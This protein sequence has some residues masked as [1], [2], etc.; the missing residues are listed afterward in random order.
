[1]PQC[2]YITGSEAQSGKSV[3]VL[4]LVEWLWN[5]GRTVGFFRPVIGSENQPDRLIH[6]ILARYGSRFPYVAMYGCTH[7]QALDLV[8][9]DS[10]EALFKLILDKYKALEQQCD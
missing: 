4:G 8:G 1:M 9:G 5:Q 7:E 3:V 2:I 10:Q 6:V